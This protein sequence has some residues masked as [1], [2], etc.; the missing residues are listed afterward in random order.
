MDNPLAG[1]I[2]SICHVIFPGFVF[3][4]VFL[5]LLLCGENGVLTG[6]NLGKIRLL[7]PG[8]GGGWGRCTLVGLVASLD[9]RSMGVWG[10]SQSPE[11]LPGSI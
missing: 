6:V 9:D 7:G 8:L 4:F 10:F 11:Y 2:F 5:F 3:Y 1:G